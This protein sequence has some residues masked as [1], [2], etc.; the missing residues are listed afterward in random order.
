MAKKKKK[1]IKEQFCI[2]LLQ[3]NSRLGGIPAFQNTLNFF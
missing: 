2:E 3:Y 1:R